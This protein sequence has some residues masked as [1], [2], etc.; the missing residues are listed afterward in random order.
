ML[1]LRSLPEFLR[2][3]LFVSLSLLAIPL[4]C[5]GFLVIPSWAVVDTTVV[6]RADWATWERMPDAPEPIVEIVQAGFAE[7]YGEDSTGGVWRCT[8]AS[9]V[10]RACW[11][12]ESGRLP[13]ISDCSMEEQLSLPETLIA[14]KF[15]PETV[16][17]WSQA[18][19]CDFG[20]GGKALISQYIYVLTTTGEV[21]RWGFDQA[22]VADRPVHQAIQL[23][24]GGAIGLAVLGVAGSIMLVL[25]KTGRTSLPPTAEVGRKAG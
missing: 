21:W 13:D 19:Y 24:V 15:P 25:Y 10:D 4:A 18:R 11:V 3:W 17:D 7:V 6:G 5:A 22:G 16:M 1:F 23:G 14:G 12:K 9:K 20:L 2:G 8:V